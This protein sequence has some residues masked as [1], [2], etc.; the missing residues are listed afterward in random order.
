MSN[1]K[2]RDAM[3]GAAIPQSNNS[4]EMVKTSSPF[5]FILWIIAFA[6]FGGAF[7]TNQYLPAYWAPANSVWVR[8]GVI[9]AFIIVALGLLYATHQGKCFVRLLK[10]SRIELRRVTWPTKHETVTTS[11]QVLLVVVVA[12]IILWCFDY[13]IGWFM[14]FIIG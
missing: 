3:G 5:D 14:K 2:S 7:M 6:L 1:D 11:W 10:D 8:I 12:A 13:I 4:A 9:L